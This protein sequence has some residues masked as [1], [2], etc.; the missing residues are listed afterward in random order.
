MSEAIRIIKKYPNRRLY[1]TTDQQLHHAGGRQ[2]AGARKRRVQGRGRQ[3]QGRPDAQHPAAD[4]PRR[5]KRRRRA[6][7][8]ERR[9]VQDHPLLR[10][11]DAGDDG[12]LPR[13][14][15]PDLHRNPEE[16]A[17]TVERDLRRHADAQRRRVERISQD[18][19]PRDP[20]PDGQLSRAERQR[21]PRNAAAD[22]K[23]D[24]QSVRQL[25]VPQLCRCQSVR[26]AQQR[27]T[28]QANPQQPRA[29]G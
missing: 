6:D 13:K 19:G 20:G 23:A 7:V 8:L 12:Q 4:H 25:P 15:H 14:E 17:G 2:K 9:A 27:T 18:A 3:D 26:A 11:R 22:A 24:A 21:V 10:Q 5:R 28:P 29:Q 16:A 1:D